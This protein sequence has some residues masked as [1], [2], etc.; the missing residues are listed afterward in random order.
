[1]N[2][3]TLSRWLTM[4]DFEMMLNLVGLFVTT[5]L[6]A[7]K[8]DA[9][10]SRL[11]WFNVFLPLFV[12]DFLQAYFIII[13]F[14]RQLSEYKRKEATMRLILSVMLLSARFTIK[15]FLYL[16]LDS[17]TIDHIAVEISSPHIKFKYVSFP[18]FFHLFVLLFK[19]CSLKKFDSFY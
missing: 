11:T 18:I 5:I 19:S 12:A 3:K 9:N 13:V 6:V 1:M 16:I 4:T 17:S 7:I 15:Q 10:S 2:V 14:V 8:V